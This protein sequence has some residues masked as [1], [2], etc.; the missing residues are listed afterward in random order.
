[1]AHYAF[2][3]TNNIVT[4]V[5]VGRDE[6]NFDWERYYGDIRGQLCKRTSYR[7]IGGDHQ[8]GG[9]PYRKNYAGV[10]YSYNAE[11]DAFIPPKTYESW[12]LNQQTCLWNPP[13]AMPIDDKRY[14]WDEAT[15]SWVEIPVL[16]LPDLETR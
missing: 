5:I 1:M 10:G 3:D 11:L 4:E 7:T 8:T 14:S 2:L 12:I 13:V 16:E 6:S 9:T 15:T